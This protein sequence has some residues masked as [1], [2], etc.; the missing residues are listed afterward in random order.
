[1]VG[2]KTV[3]DDD[4]ELTCRLPGLANRSPRRVV[5]DSSF[6]ISPGLKM[7]QTAHRVPVIIFGAEGNAPP[8]YPSGVEA[9]VV[10]TRPRGALN[11]KAVLQSLA[12][13]GVTRVLVEAGPTIAS[14]FLEADL[15]DEVVI[16]RGT[17]PLGAQ[18]RK[19]FGDR[20]LE[21]L[22]DPTRWQLALDRGLSG[23]RL[24]HHRRTGR[25]GT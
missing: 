23:D 8:R 25:L 18:G 9:R 5:L 17:E 14:A 15:A 6:R 16:G 13:D 4:P 1:M 22:D 2:R 24:T 12:H 11:L 19:P 20:G 7:F 3:E 10:S 21:I